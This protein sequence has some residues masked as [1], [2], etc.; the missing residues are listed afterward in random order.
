LL[1]SKDIVKLVRELGDLPVRILLSFTPVSNEKDLDFLEWLGVEIPPGF[2]ELI[3]KAA[4]PQEAVE[5]SLGLARN[6]L[7]E[8]CE[9][10]RSHGPALGLQIER[11]TRRNSAT[12]R[13]MLSDLGAFYH[14]LVE[15]PRTVVSQGAS[16]RRDRAAGMPPWTP[17]K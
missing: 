7:T 13:Q 16:A 11:I 4:S 12:A 14:R 5:Q 9:A 15:R 3:R 8:V 10:V 2:R 1:D 17:I 6:I